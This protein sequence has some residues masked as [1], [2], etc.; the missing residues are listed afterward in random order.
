MAERS[1]YRLVV[2]ERPGW[3]HATGSGDNVPRNVHRFLREAYA[4]CVAHG[5]D[6][7]LLELAFTGESL[8]TGAI[9][10]IVSERSTDG[11]KLRRIAY[12]DDRFA[13]D[14]EKARFAE[15]VALNRAVNVRLFRGVGEAERWLAQP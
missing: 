14:P 1:E 15:T 3:L 13:D 7:L 12:V 9:F 11:A 8:P 10:S 4:A 6:C 2:T 5:R